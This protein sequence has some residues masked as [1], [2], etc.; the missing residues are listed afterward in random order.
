MA[1]LYQSGS[2]RIAEAKKIRAERLVKLTPEEKDA[3]DYFNG[4]GF[5]K[6]HQ[7][8]KT[9]PNIYDTRRSFLLK[10]ENLEMRDKF[11]K[12]YNRKK[13]RIPTET[14]F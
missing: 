10:M 11:L 5:Y 3:F 1:K 6:K 7:N 14:N 9:S 13:I 8:P 2:N 4:M 12:A